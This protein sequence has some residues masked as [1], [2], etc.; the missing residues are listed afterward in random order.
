MERRLAEKEKVSNELI[1]ENEE[2]RKRNMKLNKGLAEKQP[3]ENMN[4]NHTKPSDEKKHKPKVIIAGDSIVKDMKGWMISR[5][6]LIKVHSFSGANT[7]DMESFLVPLLNKKLD[8]LILHAGTN[9]LAYSNANQVAER[10]VKLRTT[11]P[12]VSYIRNSLRFWYYAS[13]ST[14]CQNLEKNIGVT[15]KI[16]EKAGVKRLR[17]LTEKSVKF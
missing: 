17:D 7:T 13:L 8:H 4:T 14:C 9:D 10:T 3:K 15:G 12:L 1:K 6:K 2:L 16:W 5:N 11:V